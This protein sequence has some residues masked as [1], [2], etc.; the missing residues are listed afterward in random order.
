MKNKVL[1][2]CTGNS[3]RSQMAEAIVNH[4]LGA[5]LGAS[6][7]TALAFMMLVIGLKP[8]GGGHSAARAQTTPAGDFLRRDRGGDYHNRIFVQLDYLT[9]E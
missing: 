3:C 7:G 8:A 5:S 2:L 9:E 4:R 6:L 1:F